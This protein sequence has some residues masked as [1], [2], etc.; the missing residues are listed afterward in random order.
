[1]LCNFNG[2][3]SEII[4]F[5]LLDIIGLTLGNFP[6]SGDPRDVKSLRN[7]IDK[8]PTSVELRFALALALV[9]DSMDKNNEL[10]FKECLNLFAALEPL[11]SKKEERANR[12]RIYF[13]IN[14]ES[15]F[16]KL[17]MWAL[18]QYSEFLQNHDR[19]D[20]AIQ[21]LKAQ[22]SEPWIRL[23]GENEKTQLQT[24]VKV[25]QRGQRITE[26]IGSKYEKKFQHWMAILIGLPFFASMM[27]GILAGSHSSYLDTARLIFAI[28]LS[29]LFI[30][31][32]FLFLLGSNKRQ[33]AFPGV[34]S[35]ALFFALFCFTFQNSLANLTSNFES[36]AAISKE[37]PID[38]TNTS[39]PEVLTSI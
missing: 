37:I 31:C 10:G 19:E 12:Y 5:W 33:M 17:R 21:L 13:P 25:L 1:M 22:A 14:P 34:I 36:T 18:F 11:F 27:G 8:H 24:E 26:S 6:N 3:N 23:A 2:K 30:V 32:I 29:T 9:Q 39:K 16:I 15:L 7:L 35:A 28:T 4:P 20:E 38:N